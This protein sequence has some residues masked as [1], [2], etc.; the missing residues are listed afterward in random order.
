MRCSEQAGSRVGE[1]RCF[2]GVVAAAQRLRCGARSPRASAELALA[3]LGAQTAALDAAARRNPR[4]APLL[5]TPEARR[6]SPTRAPANTGVCPSTKNTGGGS[7]A[8]ADG[9]VGACAALMQRA[10]TQNSPCGLFCAWRA[11]LRL[12]AQG[13]AAQR[14]PSPDSKPARAGFVPGEGQPR[15]AAGWI[16]VSARRIY[17]VPRSA[18]MRSHR[19]RPAEREAQGTRSA[20]EGAA[21][22][23]EHPSAPALPPHTRHVEQAR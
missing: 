7:K 5:A 15:L 8:G 20:A 13:H 23:P 1:R 11:P 18:A 2:A 22:K 6:H 4:T 17:A 9:G 12:Q 21:S 3:A 16:V 19:S 10:R 14:G